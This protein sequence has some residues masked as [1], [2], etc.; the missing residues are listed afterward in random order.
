MLEMA[1]LETQIL[2]NLQ[3]SLV[4]PPPPS[5]F[6]NPGSA[7]ALLL[8]PPAL[9]SPAPKIARP[10]RFKASPTPWA[11]LLLTFEFIMVADQIWAAQLTG[12]LSIVF[13]VTWRNRSGNVSGL[14]F[15]TESV[16]IVRVL[17]KQFFFKWKRIN[18]VIYFQNGRTLKCIYGILLNKNVGS[19]VPSRPQTTNLS[20]LWLSGHA[21]QYNL[22][23]IISL[24][25]LQAETSCVPTKN[26]FVSPWPISHLITRGRKAPESRF[27]LWVL[28]LL[29]VVFWISCAVTK[30]KLGLSLGTKVKICCTIDSLWRSSAVGRYWAGRLDIDVFWLFFF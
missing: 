17:L 5:P 30:P 13:P 11:F 15:A 28:L 18:G 12:W 9:P 24:S 7:P 8:I 21:N 22:W 23:F 6:E 10:G 16:K 26:V 2:K 25:A 27:R 3:S 19:E 14:P 20:H 29:L 4:P 1:I